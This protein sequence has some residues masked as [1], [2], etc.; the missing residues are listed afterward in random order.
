MCAHCR[1]DELLLAWELRLFNVQAHAVHKRGQ[2]T[3]E[4]ALKQV[5]S[6]PLL[7]SMHNLDCNEAPH[8]SLSWLRSLQSLKKSSFGG[9]RLEFRDKAYGM[10]PRSVWWKRRAL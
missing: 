10:S 8:A 1:L 7:L 4:D 5:A 2:V 9:L 3:A 6:W